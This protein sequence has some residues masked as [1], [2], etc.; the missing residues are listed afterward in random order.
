MNN[1]HLPLSS[2]T[3]RREI[4]RSSRPIRRL[5]SAPDELGVSLTNTTCP[6]IWLADNGNIV[7]VGTDATDAQRDKLPDDLRVQS[8]Q[9]MVMI[10][11]VTMESAMTALANEEKRPD[12]L[13]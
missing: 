13:T 3:Y 2:L 5:G 1:D 11:R 7:L 12:G 8:H 6:D 4:E 10:P 9:R